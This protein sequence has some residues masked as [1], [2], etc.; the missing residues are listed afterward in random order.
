MCPMMG[1]GPGPSAV[2]A[3]EH[4]VYSGSATPSH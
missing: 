3:R 1:L 2:T 4:A